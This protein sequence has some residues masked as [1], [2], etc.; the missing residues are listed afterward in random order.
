M[1]VKKATL[2][3][4]ADSIKARI[5]AFTIAKG[6]QLKSTSVVNIAGAI[7]ND[8]QLSNKKVCIIDLDAQANVFTAFGLEADMLSEN[9]D[10]SAALLG[11]SNSEGEQVSGLAAIKNATFELYNDG[12]NTIDCISSNERCDLLEMTILTNLETFKSPTTLLRDVCSVLEDYY[13]Y[14]IIDTPPAYSLIVSNVFMVDRVEIYV[15]F[16]PDTY[17]MR[18]VIKTIATFDTFV[19]KNPTA[20]F[21]GVFATKVKT[22]TNIHASI[23]NTVRTYTQSVKKSYIKT[24]IPNSIKASN[25]VYYEALPAVLSSKRGDLVKEYLELWEE[26][27]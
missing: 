27:K 18:S 3:K 9:E 6:G 25:S 17:S 11:Y 16:E 14:I 7:L 10:L 1:T 24:F 20:R 22:N 21:G 12:E 26:I 19:E 8:E 4:N 23:I 5:L 15:P 13:D 2:R